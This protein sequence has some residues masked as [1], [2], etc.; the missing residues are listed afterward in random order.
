[1]DFKVL[2][3]D[4]DE[5]DRKQFLINFDQ[6]GCEIDVIH[7]LSDI[8]DMV[9]SIID[10]KPDAVVSD[11][12]LKEKEP[13]LNYDGAELLFLLRSFKSKLPC[14]LLTS[15]EAEAI[16][17]IYD[18]NFVHD[19]N[20]LIPEDCDKPSFG[21]KVFQQLTVNRNKVRSLKKRYS[22]LHDIYLNNEITPVLARE[23]AD[24]SDEIEA[25]V[26]FDGKVGKEIK[27]I[28]VMKKLDDILEFS[29]ELMRRIEEKND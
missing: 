16:K 27:D 6:D 9:A 20:E 1:M 4:E 26:F 17:N 12:H 3:I 24:L 21:E 18:V 25:Y 10:R 5:I 15:Y 8:D 22:E 19:K 11:Y 7:P 23:L 13:S 2:Y 14:F 28:F 29:K